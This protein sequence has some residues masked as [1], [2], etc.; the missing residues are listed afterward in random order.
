M[1]NAEW[2]RISKTPAEWE[3]MTEEGRNAL[4]GLAHAY[5]KHL[6]KPHYPHNAAWRGHIAQRPIAAG[7][8]GAWECW[9]RNKDLPR[10]TANDRTHFESEAK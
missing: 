8:G 2:T 3:A 9:V 6:A 10:F 7:D 4:R 1:S 5:T